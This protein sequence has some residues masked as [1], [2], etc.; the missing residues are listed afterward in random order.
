[1][2][3]YIVN[4]SA[5]VKQL[6]A[7]NSTITLTSTVI[8]GGTAK[9]LGANRTL[10]DNSAFG[11]RY[12]G[13]YGSRVVAGQNVGA[14]AYSTSA[15]VALTSV[16]DS[17]TADKARFTLVAH[18][19]SVGDIINIT[20]STGG[21]MDG[22]HRITAVPTAN[23]FDTD[24]TYVASA[25]AGSYKLYRGNFA[26]MTKGKYLIRRVTDELAG[27]SNT[28]LRSGGSE[29]YARSI[30]KVEAARSTRFATAIRAGYWDE[31]NG[32]WTTTPTT[33]N[34]FSTWGTDQAAT[35]TYAIPG[36]LVYRT[37]KPLPVQDDYKAKTN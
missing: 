31:F 36:E 18:G 3:N 28:V 25:T 27:L 23:T 33:A 11:K 4:P 35:P 20:G 19:R 8:R 34:D 21:V 24:R 6:D 9:G 1:M 2:A 22:I 26:T 32:V 10:L 37:G 13:V 17:G 12:Q 16:A 14:A 30:H 7:S 5:D 15:A 29:G